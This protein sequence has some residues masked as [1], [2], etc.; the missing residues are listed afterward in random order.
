MAVFKLS[1][2]DSE[3]APV[4]VKPAPQDPIGVIKLVELMHDAGFPPGVINVVCGTDVA[5]SPASLGY[6]PSGRKLSYMRNA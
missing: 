4:V 2:R 5:A 6:G 1:Q 3:P